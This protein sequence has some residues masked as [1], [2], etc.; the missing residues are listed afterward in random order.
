MEDF[1]HVGYSKEVLEF[2]AVSKE[3]CDFVETA[4][5]MTRED[6]V[7]RLQK[8]IPLLYLK[9]A[10]LPEVV[11]SDEGLTEDVVTEDDYNYLYGE[12]HRL[13]G[14]C[15]D[16]L[17]VF[18]DN[19]QYSESPVVHSIAEKVCD[20]YQDL[21]NFISSFRCG[22]PEVIEE[23]L[24]QLNESFELYWGKSCAGVLRAIHHVVFELKNKSDQD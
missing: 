20:I 19:M 24:W 1:Q 17:E 12:L 5:Q 6:F 2:V 13:M 10:L 15:D 21:K 18:D 3:F 23:A 22:I 8:F 11:C 14:D 16:Y 7:S 9:G 4:S